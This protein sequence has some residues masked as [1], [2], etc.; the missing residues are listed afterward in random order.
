MAKEIDVSCDFI[1]KWLVCMLP[2]Q[3]MVV[4]LKVRKKS[5]EHT[6][7]EDVY[8]HTLKYRRWNNLLR[9]FST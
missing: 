7:W 8:M 2:N 3:M 1:E 6:F 4:L 9:P 5:E